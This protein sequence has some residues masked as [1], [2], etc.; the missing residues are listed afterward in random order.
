[1]KTANFGLRSELAARRELE[2]QKSLS[3]VHRI[4]GFVALVVCVVLLIVNHFMGAL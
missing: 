2:R 3:R 1:M 4:I